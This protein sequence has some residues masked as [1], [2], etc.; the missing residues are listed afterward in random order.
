MVD[1]SKVFDSIHK[2]KMAQKLLAFG[3]L[4]ITVTAIMMLY[5]T[6]KVKVCSPDGDPDFFDIVVCA[7]QGDS[8]SRYLFIICFHY[9]DEVGCTEGEGEINTP[10]TPAHK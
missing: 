1:I 3:L 5:K 6:T 4:K 10:A 9:C 8:L 2:G 7:L